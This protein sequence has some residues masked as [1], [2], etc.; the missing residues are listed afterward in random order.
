M[1]AEILATTA[2]LIPLP[3]EA[4]QLLPRSLRS[5]PQPVGYA[6]ASVRSDILNGKTN[7]EAVG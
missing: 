5:V 3:W 2:S 1:V 6:V 7:E 4:E